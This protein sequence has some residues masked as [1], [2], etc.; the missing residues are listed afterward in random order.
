MNRALLRAFALAAMVASVAG[1]AGCAVPFLE[2]EPM[3]A[4]PERPESFGRGGIEDAEFMRPLTGAEP[5]AY[6]SPEEVRES[7]AS[8]RPFGLAE[9]V[10]VGLRNSPATRRSWAQARSDA[11]TAAAESGSWYP[12]ISM[13]GDIEVSRSIASEGSEAFAQRDY[14]P[15][16]EL[17]WL[18][19]DFGGRTGKI[20]AALA[21]LASANYAH[22]QQILDSVL[23][24][25][26]AWYNLAGA[27]HQVRESRLSVAEAE[28]SV[29]AA[30]ARMKAKVATAYDALQAETT[31]A[32]IRIQLE[33]W[34]GQERLARGQLA[35]AI[36]L[37]AN[38]VLPLEL[39]ESGPEPRAITGNVEEWIEMARR[40]R[41]DVAAA[42]AD[43]AAGEAEVRVA[44]SALLPK[45]S[46]QASV[47]YMAVHAG[48]TR[49]Q[50]WPYSAAATLSV[51]LFTGLSNWN[52][53]RQAEEQEEVLRATALEQEQAAI[54]EVWASYT[55]LRTASAMVETSE[56]W[57][58]A[59]RASYRAARVAY[60]NGLGNIIELLDA[61]IALSSARAQKVSADTNWFL[62]MTQLVHDVGLF[63]RELPDVVDGSVSDVPPRADSRPDE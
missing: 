62:S 14:G 4:A 26:Q 25:S 52:L 34:Q 27:R 13:S 7:A 1:L 21:T 3:R 2:F 19:L 43:L 39:S 5:V 23:T 10:D 58:E 33:S 9:L 38:A 40:Q 53:L 47:D 35:Q 8:G 31:L 45:I 30:R 12:Q 16:W 42:W 28:A 54:E 49:E 56:R 63:S 60:G 32:Q 41:P 61:Q 20:E 11:A 18:L 46:A 57:V 51:P 36:G 50:G 6:T 17:S 29:R 24:I 44:R 55:N 48:P 59:A 22:D 15:Q 37:P